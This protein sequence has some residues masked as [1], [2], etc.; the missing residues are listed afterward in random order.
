MVESVVESFDSSGH[1]ENLPGIVSKVVRNET[2][3]TN[4]RLDEFEDRS[5]R[6]NLIFYGLVDS[7][8]VI[9]AQSQCDVHESLTRILNLAFPDDSISRVHC[10]DTI[11]SLDTRLIPLKFGS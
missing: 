10:L 8:T 7:L 6:D 1:D 4:S 2:A 11:F 3:T 9:W 5:R